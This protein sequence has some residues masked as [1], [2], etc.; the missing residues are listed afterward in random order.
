MVGEGVMGFLV[1]GV[2][3]WGVMVEGLGWWED[4]CCR[5]KGGEKWVKKPKL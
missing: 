2:G 1:K 3:G 5:G 4:F